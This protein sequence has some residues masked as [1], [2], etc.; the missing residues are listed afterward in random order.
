VRELNNGFYTIIL[1]HS[2][3]MVGATSEPTIIYEM[4]LLLSHKPTAL[5]SMPF[6]GELQTLYYRQHQLTRYKNKGK[7]TCNMMSAEKW[8]IIADSNHFF[9]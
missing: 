9:Q 5:Q 8:A 4:V 6:S 2:S 7:T 1:L 3:S